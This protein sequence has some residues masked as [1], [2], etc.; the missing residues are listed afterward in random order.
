MPGLRCILPRAVVPPSLAAPSGTLTKPLHSVTRVLCHCSCRT[1][2]GTLWS[3]L[4]IQFFCKNLSIV[5][6]WEG[7][8]SRQ[9]RIMSLLHLLFLT[10]ANGNFNA[11]LEHIPS[12]NNPTANGISRQNFTLFLSLAPQAKRTNTNT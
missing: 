3:T 11:T 8:T 6:A 7:K 4:K 9:P 5:Q 2:L 10:A 1:N 12:I